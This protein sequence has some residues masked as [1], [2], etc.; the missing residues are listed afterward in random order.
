MKSTVL[1]FPI[2]ENIDM[3]IILPNRINKDIPD[4]RSAFKAIE[5]YFHFKENIPYEEK[6]VLFK[7]PK[8]RFDDSYELGDVR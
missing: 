2:D 1:I 3:Y 8:M 7:L 4:R 6:T 5:E